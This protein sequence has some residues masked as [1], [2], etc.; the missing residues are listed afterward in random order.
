[1]DARKLGNAPLSPKG[2]EQLKEWR[3]KNVPCLMADAS[4]RQAL[5]ALCKTNGLPSESPW[6][7]EFRDA[8]ALFASLAVVKTAKRQS[9]E[10][11]W[12]QNTGKTWKTLKQFPERLR[13]MAKEVK[14]MNASSFFSPKLLVADK[15]PSDSIQNIVSRFSDL[16]DI[17][18]YYANGVEAVLQKLPA[19][20]SEYYWREPGHSPWIDQLLQLVNHV[21]GHFR[22]S[23]L[24]GLLNAA[25]AVLR[26]DER[27]TNKGYD[28]QTLADYRSRRKRKAR[29]T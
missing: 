10:Q 24:A 16:P 6:E 22:D 27:N 3:D 17:L 26:P 25:R 29:K 14:L 12:A 23:E 13:N 28:A 20:T 8:V 15:V 1:M 2:L 11:L 5:E 7:R 21:T 9:F 19:A 18:Y 4:F